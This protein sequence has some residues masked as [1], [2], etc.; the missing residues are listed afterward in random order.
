MI[1][2]LSTKFDDLIADGTI[3]T[4]FGA[5]ENLILA[6]GF[7]YHVFLPSRTVLEHLITKS[8]TFSER[9]I[10][11]LGS[12]KNNYSD[13]AGLAR[14]VEFTVL[15]LPDGAPSIKERRNQNKRLP[16]KYFEDSSSWHRFRLLVEHAANDGG[17]YRSICTTIGENLGL[18]GWFQFDAAHGAGGTTATEYARFC[19]EAR[20][21]LCIVDSDKASPV[22]SLGGTAQRVRDLIGSESSILIEA[23]VL[24]VRSA[25]NFVP[26]AICRE[27]F[28]GN[29]GVLLNLARIERLEDC[30]HN[31]PCDQ[32]LIRFFDFKNGL[33]RSHIRK[34]NS[35]ERRFLMSMWHV[36]C[37][38]EVDFDPYDAD[39][40]DVICGGVSTRLLEQFQSFTQYY[41]NRR[42][43]LAE[44]GRHPFW[45][46]LAELAKQIIAY[47]IRPVVSRA[48]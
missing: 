43:A 13:L 3:E 21:T 31:A 39:V 1:V 9:Q 7:G 35:A 25:E 26:I 18:A 6:H 42:K 10:A 12:I 8:T 23:H 22:A 38:E 47:G 19:T 29:R 15:A 36:L 11:T 16:L 32:Q 5:I 14:T 2:E 40:D 45:A 24:Q 34:S 41:R 27:L 4:Y 44:L 46:E 37:P 28:A 33:T 30:S 48:I 20:P 17:F